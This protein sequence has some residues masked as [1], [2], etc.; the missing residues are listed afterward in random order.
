MKNKDE[1]TIETVRKIQEAI[2]KFSKEIEEPEVRG[3]LDTLEVEIEGIWE[4]FYETIKQ[5]FMSAAKMTDCKLTENQIDEIEQRY[6]EITKSWR[7]YKD[8][9]MKECNEIIGIIQNGSGKTRHID[10]FTDC[11]NPFQRAWYS[12]RADTN[13][14]LCEYITESI[15]NTNEKAI[16]KHYKAIYDKEGISLRNRGKEQT[17]IASVFGVIDYRRTTLKPSDKDSRAKF[18]NLYTAKAISPLD[19]NLMKDGMKKNGELTLEMRLFIAKQVARARRYA[20]AAERINEM[21]SKTYTEDYIGKVA[22]QIGGEVIRYEREE[23]ERYTREGLINHSITDTDTRYLII[24][25]FERRYFNGDVNAYYLAIFAQ[26]DKNNGDRKIEDRLINKDCIIEEN[27]TDFWKMVLFIMA[28]QNA[29]DNNSLVVLANSLELI[30]TIY[31]HL[32]MAS[33]Y[34]DQAD[35]LSLP[36][37]KRQEIEDE[38]EENLEYEEADDSETDIVYSRNFLGFNNISSLLSEETTN[39]SREILTIKAKEYVGRWDL[40]EDVIRYEK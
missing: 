13:K 24:Y 36:I 3:S 5:E 2:G 26:D 17:H 10:L 40:V 8:E 22:K 11:E 27:L 21:Y 6:K 33:V 14:L 37:V 29:S 23:A 18:D 16:I 25:R 28:R 15:R 34:L 39:F 19:K 1:L 30:P 12:L 38:Y 31:E 20:D 4:S 35:F 9:A 32:E 7:H